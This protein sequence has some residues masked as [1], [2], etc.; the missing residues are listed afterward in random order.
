[1][2]TETESPPASARKI[3][4]RYSAP[5]LMAVLGI[6]IILGG[7][8]AILVVSKYSTSRKLTFHAGPKSPNPSERALEHRVQLQRKIETLSAPPSAPQ[9]ILT[10]GLSK[11]ILPPLPEVGVKPETAMPLMSAGGAKVAFATAG[12]A[13][14]GG[15]AVNGNGVPINFFGIKDLSTSVVI[16]IDVSDSM[17]TRTGDAAGR[18]LVR[19]GKEQAFQTVR[20]EAIRLVQSLT[21]QTRFD[22]IRWAGSARAWQ[23]ELVPATDENKA[24]A[25]AHIQN[26]IDFKSAK[27][28]ADRPGGTRHDYALELAFSLK[29]E[30]IYMLTDG[31]ATA[32]QPETGRLK[33]IPPQALYKIAEDGQKTL[34]KKARLHTLYFLN[35]KEKKTEREMLQQLASRNGGQ[36]RTVPVKSG[37]A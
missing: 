11:I 22:V 30:T 31:N 26:E 4:R 25:C 24:A 34:P 14:A 9:R 2:E 18:Q 36:F 32:Y 8:A 33:N 19:Q 21:P 6:H 29:P 15:G 23:P 13:S 37:G 1:M 5:V 7:L 17:F 16:M 27:P 35:A 28:Q 10:T 3:V 12:G 20:A